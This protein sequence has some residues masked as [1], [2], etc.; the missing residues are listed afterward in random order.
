MYK[1]EAG[2]QDPRSTGS[3]TSF[4]L[5]AKIQP[6]FK[7]T[8]FFFTFM[9]IQDFS[10]RLEGLEKAVQ[11]QLSRDLPRKLD[12]IAVGLFKQNFQRESFFGHAWKE[13]KRR[14]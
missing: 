10:K 12:N 5:T 13:V 6:F 14:Q 4:F 3:S 7:L 2:E 9:Q 8:N 11:Q 1:K